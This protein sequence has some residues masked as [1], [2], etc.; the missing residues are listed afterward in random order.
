L[1][2]SDRDTRGDDG[3]SVVAAGTLVDRIFV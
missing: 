3:A 1:V 2:A